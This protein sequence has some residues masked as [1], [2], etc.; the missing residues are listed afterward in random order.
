MDALKAPSVPEL[1]RVQNGDASS[2]P[3]SV[4]IDYYTDCKSVYDLLVSDKEPSPSDSG[5]TLYL[6]YCR[7]KIMSHS[8][9]SVAWC[10]TTDQLAD[11]L[12]KNDVDD[13]MITA[14]LEGF[15]TFKHSH[16][17]AGKLMESEKGLPP[18]K[19]NAEKP[20]NEAYILS[21]LQLWQLMTKLPEAVGF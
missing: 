13:T 7:E 16:V 10:C 4:A 3:Q 12:T 2:I 14:A 21:V 15:I 19:K 6:R 11:V 18:P 20:G 8:V 5:S 9:R 1:L 17:S